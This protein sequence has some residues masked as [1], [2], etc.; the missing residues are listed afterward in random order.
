MEKNQDLLDRFGK[1]VKTHRESHGWSQRTLAE[2]A[3]MTEK[4]VGEIER[5]VAEPSIT[6]IV[7]LA[8]GLKVRVAALVPE[9]S[10]ASEGHR[11]SDG[12]RPAATRVAKRSVTR[13]PS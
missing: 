13:P 11:P 7:A 10:R 4:H 1:M 9:S 3:G 6:A 8:T 2:R 5:G 12:R